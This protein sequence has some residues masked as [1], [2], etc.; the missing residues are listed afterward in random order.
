MCFFNS[1][2][3]H[4]CKTCWDVVCIDLCLSVFVS[5]YLQI[6]GVNLPVRRNQALIVKNY[7]Q[8]SAR[9]SIELLGEG[10]GKQERRWQIITEVQ[11]TD[12]CHW[13]WHAKSCSTYIYIS[14]LKTLIMFYALYRVIRMILTYSCYSVLLIWWQLVLRVT[15]LSLIQFVRIFSQ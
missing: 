12:W 9:L 8:Y 4:L 13:N 11:S 10:K 15:I 1:M 6:E 3:V 14:L 2:H 7:C 5:T